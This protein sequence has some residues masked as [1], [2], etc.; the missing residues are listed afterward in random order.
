[1]KRRFQI[2][3]VFA[4][5]P[6]LGNPVAVILDA[7]DLSGDEMQRITRW[8]NLSEST[9]VLPP[10]SPDA[11]YRLR[12]FTLDREMPFAGHPTLGSCR[13]WLETGGKPAD[14]REIVQECGAG[15]V[16]IR[17]ANDRL[18]FAA[19]PLIRSG[20]VDE[21]K[22]DEVRAFLNVDRDQFVDT[23]W[24]DNG[25]GWLGV[26]LESAEAVLALEPAASHPGRIDV[27]VVGPYP[28]GSEADFEL[29][30][31][32]SDQ[33]GAIREDPVTGSLNAS[34]GQWLFDS[35]RVTSA[36]L[37][38]QGTR[39]GRAG[40]IAVSRDDTGD[41]WVGGNTASIVNGEIEA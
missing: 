32:F 20:N 13:A 35:G 40:R 27:G 33:H 23:R 5:T 26:M 21:S 37:A 41:V 7:E 1:M 11:D 17:A 24:I 15:L 18:S 29:R 9:F 16:R 38:S 25:P 10:S 8:M 39:I 30:A 36:Y 12:I 2:V 34:V 3:D 6:F 14:K 4:E 19:P 28:D 31:L 22:I